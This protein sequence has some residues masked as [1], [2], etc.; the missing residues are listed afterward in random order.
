VADPRPAYQQR[1][2]FWIGAIAGHDR[3]HLQISN[4]R[5]AAVGLAALLAWLAL[6]PGVVRGAWVVAPIV[7][8]F[9]L[10][11]VHARVLNARDRAIRAKAYF[12]RGL[13]R[14]D[15]TWMGSGADGVRYA[16]GHPYAHD[17]DL[18]GGGSMFQLLDTAVTEAG[19]DA[20]AAWLRRPA[21]LVEILERQQAIAELRDR[22]DFREALAIVA[23]EAH[24]SR[25]GSLTTWGATAP[26][27]FGRY[28]AWLFAGSAAITVGMIALAYFTSVTATAV[29]FW[30]G[31]QIGLVARW[32]RRLDEVLQRV[33]AAERDLALLSDLLERVEQETFTSARLQKWHRAL[34]A[35]GERPSKILARLRFFITVRDIP[36]NEF[37][38]PFAM[39]LLARSQS[40]VAIDRWH[41]L[42]R[43]RLLQW[44]AAI[45]ELEALAAFG[46]YAFE[47]PGDVFPVLVSDGPVFESAGLAHPLI[48]ETAAVP[49][50][51]ALGDRAPHVLIVSGSN[52]SGKSTLLRAVGLNAV[53]AMAGATVRARRLTISPVRLGTT[54]RVEDSLQEGHSRFYAEVLRIRDI[55]EDTA[56]HPV[57]FLLDEILHGTN[58]HDRRIGSEA[59]VRALVDAG[60]IGLVTTHDLALTAVVE[61]LAGRARN[62]HFEDRIDEGRMTFDYHMRDGVVERS[63]ALELMRAVGLKV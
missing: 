50:D 16:A 7:L 46:T 51:L 28:L 6:G 31:V 34:T 25:T 30:I 23:A 62:V 14:I 9:A 49:N 5:L 3:T 43:A 39:L 29:V 48:A 61:T 38:R 21:D 26:A 24:V 35:D 60:A 42:H 44:V 2:S 52:M 32:R 36:R 57:L 40:A 41:A 8:F 18:F 55:V 33:D 20:L 47:H 58:S 53:L 59:I 37:V 10:V 45:G 4:A 11:V 27:G 13:S 17:L 1:L 15:G 22:S 19:E 12:E 54:L 56:A 63:N